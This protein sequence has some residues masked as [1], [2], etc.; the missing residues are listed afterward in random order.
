VRFDSLNGELLGYVLKMFSGADITPT[1]VVENSL[2]LV[3]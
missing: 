3:A 1:N 2:Q